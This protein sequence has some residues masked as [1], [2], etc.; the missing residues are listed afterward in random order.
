M[1]LVLCLYFNNWIL[2]VLILPVV[3]SLVVFWG[4]VKLLL[5]GKCVTKDFS[6]GMYLV[7][8]PLMMLFVQQKYF[9]SCWGLAF[10]GCFG[11]SFLCSYLLG[12]FSK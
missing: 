11:V 7:H 2:T 5:F 3:L 1:I 6:F 12:K 8:Y 4:A 10:A 9:I